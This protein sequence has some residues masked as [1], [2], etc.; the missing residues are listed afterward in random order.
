MVRLL[1]TFLLGWICIIIFFQ[2]VIL[3]ANCHTGKLRI[4]FEVYDS[5]PFDV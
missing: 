1:G 3:V 2:Q 4:Y 5:D